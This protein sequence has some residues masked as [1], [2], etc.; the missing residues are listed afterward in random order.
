MKKLLGLVLAVAALSAPLF[1][2]GS[3]DSA[4]SAKKNP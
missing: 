2:N 1:A 4:A 3:Q